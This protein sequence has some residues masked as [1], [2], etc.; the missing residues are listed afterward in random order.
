MSA[1]SV[2]H[3]PVN[4]EAGPA[5]SQDTPMLPISYG[6]ASSAGASSNR[7]VAS[8]PGVNRRLQPILE[9]LADSAQRTP[10]AR[11]RGGESSAAIRSASRSD[12]RLGLRPEPRG[13]QLAIENPIGAHADAHAIVAHDPKRLAIVARGNPEPLQDVGQRQL[14]RHYEVHVDI[15]RSELGAAM[16]LM[17]RREQWWQCS[18]Q[19]ARESIGMEMERVRTN[20]LVAAEDMESQM[21]ALMQVVYAA[22]V[23]ARSSSLEALDQQRIS[24]ELDNYTKNL[25]RQGRM[26]IANAD[27]QCRQVYAEANQYKTAALHASSELARV[28][29]EAERRIQELQQNAQHGHQQEVKIGLLRHELIEANRVCGELQDS[30]L[31]TELE[32]QLTIEEMKMQYRVVEGE[33]E[34]ERQ[35]NLGLQKAVN[36]FSHKRDDE[37]REVMQSTNTLQELLTQSQQSWTRASDDLRRANDEMR[38]QQQTLAAQAAQV[39]ILKSELLECQSRGGGDGG[40][41]AIDR[42]RSELRAESA[43]NTKAQSEARQQRITN[44]DLK[45]EV[46]DLR[47]QIRDWE[48]QYDWQYS[49]AGANEKPKEEKRRSGLAPQEWEAEDE[50]GENAESVIRGSESPCGRPP[51]TSAAA[52]S[53]TAEHPKP[54]SDSRL[55]EADRIKVNGWPKP[56]MFRKWRMDVTDEV[57]AAS[58]RPQRTFE[59]MMKVSEAGITYEDLRSPGDDMATL[60]A[61]LASALAFNASPEFQKTLQTRKAEALREGRMVAG[62]QILFMIDQHFKMTEADGSVFDTEHLFSVKMRG[63]RLAEFLSSWDQVIAG[64]KKIPTDDTLLA[65]LMRNL[66]TCK[67]MDPDIAYFDRLPS[68]HSDKSYEYILRCARAVIERNRLQWYRD[69]LS[70][71]L[72]GGWVNAGKAKGKGKGKSGSKGSSENRA[73]KGENRKGKGKGK[74]KRSKGKSRS[75]SRDSTRS[76]PSVDICRLHL[77]GKCKSG[78]DCPKRHNPPCRFFQRGECRNGKDCVFP[79][80][81]PAATANTGV[82]SGEAGNDEG[83]T[84]VEGQKHSRG[85]SRQRSKEGRS[86]TPRAAVCVY[87]TWETGCRAAGTAWS[88]VARNPPARKYEEIKMR[89]GRTG[90]V[91]IEGAEIFDRILEKGETARSTTFVVRQ[92]GYRHPDKLRKFST[93]LAAECAVDRALDLIEEISDDQ[94]DEDGAFTKTATML[95]DQKAR[96]VA[97]QCPSGQGR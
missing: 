33:L 42:L 19:N 58:T 82:K 26:M 77:K 8:L 48:Q 45:T 76:D 75:P 54:P 64:L 73:E 23:K 84:K 12:R 78:K 65:L 89:C 14:Q 97:K 79:H 92:V 63:D 46:A 51:M 93:T 68:D 87:R 60:D 9:G 35:R 22:Q 49:Q 52:A 3:R 39:R 28:K 53:R 6:P 90:S 41:E 74:G 83:W 44:M 2:Q 96:E 4:A 18:I 21:K 1:E 15:L 17:E 66:R 30:R 27:Q 59:W 70:R 40:Q 11:S 20:E 72:N 16:Q 55:K 71:S 56:A 47:A 62:R 31:Q 69:E 91:W 43:M 67:A 50:S 25:E 80:H 29:T 95:N 85:R 36:D 10:P 24:Q 94:M 61:K 88:A 13:T 34:N 5:A 81:Q 37:Q 86:Q 57:V 38:S 32:T 7:R